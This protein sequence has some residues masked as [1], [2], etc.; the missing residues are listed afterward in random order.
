MDGVKVR[1][2]KTREERAELVR[3][4][5]TGL[6]RAVERFMLLTEPVDF[7]PGGWSGRAGRGGPTREQ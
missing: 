7:G 1:R 2:R 6:G 3:R 5:A 4:G